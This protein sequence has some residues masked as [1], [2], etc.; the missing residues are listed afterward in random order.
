[1]HFN[2]KIIFHNFCYLLRIL[3]AFGTNTYTTVN[4]ISTCFVSDNFIVFKPAYMCVG[5]WGVW[6]VCLVDEMHH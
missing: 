3:G 6:G 4:E 5:G 1:M 2:S